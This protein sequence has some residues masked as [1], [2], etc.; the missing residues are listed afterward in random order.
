MSSPEFL[1]KLLKYRTTK[2]LLE[3][4]IEGVNGRPGDLDMI[5]EAGR[6]RGLK[7]TNSFRNCYTMFQGDMYATSYQLMAKEPWLFF[8]PP[9][10]LVSVSPSQSE[11]LLS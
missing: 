10:K 7:H 11:N 5:E 6:T 3:Q 4:Y 9:S 2:S 1:F 8:N